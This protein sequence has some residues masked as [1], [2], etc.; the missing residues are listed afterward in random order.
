MRRRAEGKKVREDWRR[1]PSLDVGS[2]PVV[3]A[4]CWLDLVTALLA[5]ACAQVND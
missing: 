3:T 2:P 5:A 1:V 4:G